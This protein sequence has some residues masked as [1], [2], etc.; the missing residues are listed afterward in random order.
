MS[1]KSRKARGTIGVGVISI[2]VAIIKQVSV[3]ACPVDGAP[4][5]THAVPSVGLSTH[6]R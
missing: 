5:L 6:A 3:T 2:Q 4:G 1:R